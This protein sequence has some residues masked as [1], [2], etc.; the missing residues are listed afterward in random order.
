M[1][2]LA[3]LLG[4]IVG[5][6]LA[7]LTGK[8]MATEIADCGSCVSLWDVSFLGMHFSG[9]GS[10]PVWLLPTLG[11]IVGAIGG[12]LVGFIYLALRRPQTEV[13]SL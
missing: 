12:L 6:P 13:S 9:E 7:F 2:I 5:I 3:G 1:L 8:D 4:A 11:A 10:V